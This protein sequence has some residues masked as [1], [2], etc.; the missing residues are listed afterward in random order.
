MVTDGLIYYLSFEMIPHHVAKRLLD[1]E[2]EP[3]NSSLHEN[4]LKSLVGDI[5]SFHVGIAVQR[6]CL[7]KPVEDFDSNDDKLMSVCDGFD[8]SR[9]EVDIFYC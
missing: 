4:A 2:V 6:L 8:Q 7:S 5:L 9:S 1:E 3:H